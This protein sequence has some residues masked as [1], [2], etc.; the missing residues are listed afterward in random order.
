M[1]ACACVGGRQS[2]TLCRSV[3][4]QERGDL[5]GPSSSRD[6]SSGTSQAVS[7]SEAKAAKGRSHRKHQERPRAGSNTSD[8][9][10]PGN[11]NRDRDLPSSLLRPR[12]MMLTVAKC[13]SA[14][15]ATQLLSALPPSL[16]LKLGVVGVQKVRFGCLQDR[17]R[18]RTGSEI[19]SVPDWLPSSCSIINMWAWMPCTVWFV[20]AVYYFQFAR[21]PRPEGRIFPCCKLE[22]GSRGT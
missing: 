7:P 1:L 19:G 14:V 15:R 4:G 5:R 20:C 11:G 16:H 12:L 17:S 8:H 22:P 3:Y 6:S 10:M 2:H 9:P 13:P 21:M 18:Y